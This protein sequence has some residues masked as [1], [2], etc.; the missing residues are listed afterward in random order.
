M[1]FRIH[2]DIMLITLQR[3]HRC[4]SRVPVWIMMFA[5]ALLSA[6][7]M[8]LYAAF[9][10]YAF[11]VTVEMDKHVSQM[12]LV[13]TNVRGHIFCLASNE[14]LENWYHTYSIISVFNF[15]IASQHAAKL[16]TFV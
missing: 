2:D 4:S 7:M 8:T 10:V 13:S 3:Y 9:D 12:V 5:V 6:S 15:L 11:R 14:L 1:L 16:C